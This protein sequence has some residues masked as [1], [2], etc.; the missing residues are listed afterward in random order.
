[1]KKIFLVLP[2]ALLAAGCVGNQGALTGAGVGAL[3][4]AAI[5]DDDDRAAGAL[6]GGALGAATGNAIARSSRPNVC[7]YQDATGSQYTAPC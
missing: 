2:I 5:A 7:V 3:A 6:V 1:M 4:G